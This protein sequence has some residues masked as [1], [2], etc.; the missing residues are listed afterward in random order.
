MRPTILPA[1]AAVLISS[2][3]ADGRRAQPVPSVRVGTAAAEPGARAHGVLEVPASGDAGAQLP[4][5]VVHGRRPGPMVAIVAGVHG[6]E[7]SPI[8]ALNRFAEELDPAAL[9]GTVVLVHLANPPA[10]FGRTVYVSPADGRNLNRSFPGRE[11]GTLTERTAH[12]LTT[13]VLARADVVV[14]VHSGDANEDLV[15]WVGFYARHGTPEVIA[16][17]RALAEASGIGIVVHFPQAPVGLAASLYTGAAAVALGKP[18][19]DIEVG[20]RGA[21]DLS[22]V[23]LIRGT[24]V[25]VLQHLRVLPGTAAPAAAPLQVRER[26]SVRSEVAGVFLPSVSA[27]D[28]VSAGELLGE[29]R[30]THG[31]LRQQLRAPV[32]GVVLVIFSTPP[33]GVGETV[34]TIAVPDATPAQRAGVGA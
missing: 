34:V 10:F 14:D 9:T 11:D 27:G 4:I 6:S 1:F 22:A 21:I 20:G 16:R 23:A 5:T 32:S 2:V 18:S 12:V 30:D 33:V 26:H 19:F 29:I 17:S 7:F 25:R 24:L 28:R 8:L 15:P 3:P 31:V 13:Q